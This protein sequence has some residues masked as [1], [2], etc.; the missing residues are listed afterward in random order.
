MQNTQITL[1][2]AISA[3]LRF[4]YQARSKQTH[5]TYATALQKFVDVVGSDTQ[6]TKDT[7]IKFLLGTSDVSPATQALYRSA[8]RR[9][10]RYTAGT[11][12]GVDVSF[13]DQVDDDYGL[14][15]PK[16]F[17]NPNMDAIQQTIDYVST[18]RNNPEELRDRTYILLLADSG[19]RVSEAC[20]L[21]VNDVDLLEGHVFITGKGDKPAI[22]HISKRTIGAM[23][24]YFRVRTISKAAPVFIHH[25]KQAGEKIIKATPGYM[26]HFVKRRI[27]EAGVDPE[28]NIRP[29]DLRHFFVTTVYRAKGIKLAQK[30]AR[31]T[32]ISTTDRYT[33]LVEDEGEA[34][35]EI[36]NR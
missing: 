4:V 21:R 13:F 14:K 5:K 15:P 6:L 27:A 9:L 11:V 20:G 24:E 12:G 28:T 3:F 31:H 35:D 1:N 34:Y 36:F 26:W 7:Y 18:I 8:V 10:Y 29:H 2:D 30:L 33:H 25:S 16:N 19:L 17:I 32:R 22:V 23:R